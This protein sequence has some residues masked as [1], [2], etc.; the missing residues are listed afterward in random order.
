[1]QRSMYVI[2]FLLISFLFNG[3]GTVIKQNN[4]VHAGVSLDTAKM[5]VQN[6][7]VNNTD[8]SGN[9]AL[10]YAS[11]SSNHVKIMKYLIQNGA[12]INHKGAGSSPLKLAIATGNYDGVKLLIDN[13]AIYKQR[14]PDGTS[15]LFY[16]ITIGDLKIIKYLISK[17]LP[18]NKEGSKKNL[19]TTIDNQIS[20]HRQYKDKSS[21]SILRDIYQK[22]L[23]NLQETRIFVENSF[24]VNVIKEKK[25]QENNIQTTVE[26]YVKKRDLKGLK[27]Y[28]DKNPNAVYYIKDKATRLMLTGPKGMKVGDIKKLVKEKR[29]ESIIIS[30]IKRVKTPYKEFTLE[31]IDLLSDMKLSDTIISAMMDV[32]TKLLANAEQKKQQEF[33][34]NEQQKM[35]TQATKEKIV[36][37]NTSNQKVDNQGNPI[38]DKVQDEIIKQGVG[39]LLD[40]LF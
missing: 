20:I 19:L 13:G 38:V 35:N 27:N 7:K 29:S 1:M 11:T 5:F 22:G 33:L 2:T 4:V 21:S 39:M 30:L 37:K 25:I 14:D 15:V 9:T 16:A 6:G 34:L 18:I 8:S 12:N 17:G 26:S 10:H 40:N 24:D 3:C 28:T 31:E 36:Y 23:T 32:T